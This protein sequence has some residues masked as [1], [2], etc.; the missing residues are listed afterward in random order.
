LN[1]DIEG[2]V[3]VKNF[4]QMPAFD[5]NAAF[6]VWLPV[7][8][9]DT[10]TRPEGIRF[11]ICPDGYTK[12][13]RGEVLFPGGPGINEGFSVT[14]SRTIPGKKISEVGRIWVVGCI[15]YHDGTSTVL[16]HTRFW[17]RS[18]HADDANWIIFSH[19][20]RYMPITGFES[21]GEQAD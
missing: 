19:E 16:H 21:W 15:S 3:T 4:G 11:V 1:L 14:L 20:F 10:I 7:A 18:A 9:E 2:I 8:P 13:G 6:G 17:F 5:Q 12:L